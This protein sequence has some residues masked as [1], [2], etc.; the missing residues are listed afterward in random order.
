MQ[1]TAFKLAVVMQKR[2]IEN[3]WQSEIWEP[4]AVMP[5]ADCDAEQGEV[6][7]DG[8]LVRWVFRGLRL[9]LKRE[10]AEG[11]YLNIST[12]EPRV[13][14]MWQIEDERA[15]PPELYDEVS[16]FAREHYRPEPKKRI[17]PR[18][19]QSKDRRPR[20]GS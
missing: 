9:G 10:E 16:T 1:Q 12:Q 6:F 13:F 11:Y 8:D 15:V 4:V 2:P 3:R 17:R 19:F 7:A 5:E 14:V 20:S 18:S